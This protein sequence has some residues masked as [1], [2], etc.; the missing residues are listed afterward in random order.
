MTT[1]MTPAAG[2]GTA[3]GRDDTAIL[4]AMTAAVRQAGAALLALYTPQA[5]PAD[6]DDMVAAGRRNEE[7]SL[8]CLRPAL[9]AARPQ[10]RWVDDDQE[11]AVLPAGEWWTVDAVEGNVNHVHGLAE[12]CV[13]V[14]LI[15]DNVPVAAAVYQ[16]VGDL[17]YTAVRGSG[18]YLNGQPLR[19]SAKTDLAAAIATTGQAEAGQDHTYRRIG[20][21]IIAMLGRALL[22]RATVPSTFPLLHVAAGHYDVFWQYEPVLPGIAAGALLVS[23]AGGVVSD[24]RGRPWQPGRTDVVMAAPGL[25]AAA[26]DAL[27]A[28]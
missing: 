12:W 10:A 2:P 28:A 4:T 21:S 18:A 7:A 25:H 27:A 5:R 11:K 19:T 8:A 3:N 16:P 17:A 20:D 14:T 9:T 23:E 13:S 15:S 24:V 26:I 1:H 6:R 22:V